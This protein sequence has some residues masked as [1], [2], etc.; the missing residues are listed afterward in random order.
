MKDVKIVIGANYGDEGKGLLTHH[1]VKDAIMQYQ[2]PI[3]ILHNGTAQRGHTVDYNPHYRHVYHHFGCGTKEGV[4]TFFAK[5]FWLHPMTFC[6]EWNELVADGIIPPICFCDPD[7]KVVTPFDMMVD[8]ATEAYITKIHQEPEHGSCGYGTWCATDREPDEIYSIS[9]YFKFIE[10]GTIDY[11]LDRVFGRCVIE[12]FNRGVDP[13]K[14]PE[15]HKYLFDSKVKQTTK[16]HFIYDLL[17]FKERVSLVSFDFIYDNYSNIIFEGAQGLGLNKN[18]ID[19]WHTT[20]FTNIKNPFDMLRGKEDFSAEVCYVT[21]SYATRHGLGFMENEVSK[22]EINNDMIDQT[23]VPNEFQG[24]LRYGCPECRTLSRIETDFRLV[25]KDSRFTQSLAV[26]H[27]NEFENIFN[28]AA[29]ISNNPF[30][31][32]KV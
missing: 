19:D 18:C 26:T 10:E 2:S 27:C 7:A 25:S 31:V 14:I 16:E 20:S 22:K 13:D 1:F 30:S 23:N 8:H 21:R 6:H 9:D 24:T 3:V 4:R 28:N 11:F 17:F 29:Y 15:F 12:L 32:L 5:T